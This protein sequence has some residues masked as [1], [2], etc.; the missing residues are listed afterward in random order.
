ML[1]L[2][3]RLPDSGALPG[4]VRETTNTALISNEKRS[5]CHLSIFISQMMLL[6]ALKCTNR[7]TSFQLRHHNRAHGCTAF[8]AISARRRRRRTTKFC[9]TKRRWRHRPV[10]GRG[11]S[12]LAPPPKRETPFG[13]G[14]ATFSKGQ[15]RTSL[16][17]WPCVFCGG[18]I[19]NL[20]Y[21]GILGRRPDKYYTLR[22]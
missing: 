7:R 6:A 5:R 22:S 1:Q 13:L 20:R 11:P 19:R 18:G 17:P 2:R 10:S 12:I 14:R 21:D 3:R 16:S 9:S 15:R 4:S 8:Q